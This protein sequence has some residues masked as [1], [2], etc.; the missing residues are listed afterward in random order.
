MIKNK[1]IILC[2]AQTPLLICDFFEVGNLFLR[3]V[4][5]LSKKC[6]T[7][8]ILVKLHVMFRSNGTF[9]FFALLC[10][11]LYW[12]GS[13]EPKGLA[14]VLFQCSQHV[15]VLEKAWTQKFLPHQANSFIICCGTTK[16]HVGRFLR[17]INFWERAAPPATWKTGAVRPFY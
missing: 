7:E 1:N 11:F 15:G 9:S 10:N 3:A 2:I 5:D 13:F 14:R 4:V 17:A 12:A 16:R 6:P 8:I